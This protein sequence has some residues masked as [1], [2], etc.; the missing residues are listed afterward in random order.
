MAQDLRGYVEW[1]YQRWAYDWGFGYDTRLENLKA[2]L[3][4][5]MAQMDKRLG[6]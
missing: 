5:S 1:D 3:R 6:P 4:E 2:L